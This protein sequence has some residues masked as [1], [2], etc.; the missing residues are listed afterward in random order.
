MT[1]RERFNQALKDGMRARDQRRVSTLRLVLAALKDR[2]IANRSE[3]SREV[4]RKNG[5][6]CVTA[7]GAH[8]EIVS[9]GHSREDVPAFGRLTNAPTNDLVRA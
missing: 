6:T 8:L 5:C 1:L 4:F 7:V 9:H 2:D 3:D